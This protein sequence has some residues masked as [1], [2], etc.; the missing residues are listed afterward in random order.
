M[1][2]P[3]EKARR[4]KLRTW[5][6]I[7]VDRI[8]DLEVE[9]LSKILAEK[10]YSLLSEATEEEL[11]TTCKEANMPAFVDEVDDKLPDHPVIRLAAELAFCQDPFAF[12]PMLLKLREEFK[13][14]GATSA[15]TAQLLL[16][17]TM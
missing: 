16:Y 13:C 10:G 12:H 7:F 3:R 1:T 4:L 17:G 14:L 11:R 8:E 9:Q 6:R 15:A 5:R 2:N